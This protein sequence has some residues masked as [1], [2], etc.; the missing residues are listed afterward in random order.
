MG[1]GLGPM[2]LA[3]IL[4]IAITT[5]TWF[6]IDPEEAGLVMRFGRFA[7]QVGGAAWVPTTRAESLAGS[8]I[9]LIGLSRAPCR[10]P[11]HGR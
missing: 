8:A 11:D 10:S 5:T 1:L 6:T 4:V 9:C 2:E 3:I 7:R